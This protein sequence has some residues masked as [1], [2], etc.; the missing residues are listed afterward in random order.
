MPVTKETT[1]VTDVQDIRDLVARRART[2]KRLRMARMVPTVT[3]ETPDQTGR[4]AAVTT[5]H[6]PEPLQAIKSL[7]V[8]ALFVLAVKPPFASPLVFPHSLEIPS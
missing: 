2:A 5:V 7:L 1:V 6:H 4:K 8:S 3:K